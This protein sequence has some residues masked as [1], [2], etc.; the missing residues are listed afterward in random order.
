MKKIS[1]V[2]L[3]AVVVFV[4][5][6]I[7][8]ST[9]SL[10]NAKKEP[11]ESEA[12]ASEAEETELSE[13]ETEV[14]ETA[15]TEDTETD[16]ASGISF[17]TADLDGNTVTSDIFKDYDVTLVHVWA[18]YCGPCI[19]EMGNYATLYENLPDNTN[20]IGLVIDVNEGDDYNVDSAKSILEDANASFTNLRLNEEL[21]EVISN[22]QYVPS[23]FFVDS[24]GNIIG[25]ILEGKG[26]DETNNKLS[27]L[28][29]Q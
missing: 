19:A 11:A 17:S 10:R 5:L 28:T 8:I 3:A 23:S 26:F 27:E 14:T 4:I 2:A 13:T 7:I 24:E 1:L 22:I 29:E 18:T 15:D 20:I 6:G 16:D 9:S 21:Y 12:V 25:D